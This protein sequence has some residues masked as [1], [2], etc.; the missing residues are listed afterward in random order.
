[1]TLQI[2]HV[3]NELSHSWLDDRVQMILQIKLGIIY[4]IR[5]IEIIL[6]ISQLFK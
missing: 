5:N 1:M 3:R 4:N 6:Q 2:L